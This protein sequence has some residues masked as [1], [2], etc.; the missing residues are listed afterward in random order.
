MV[1][2]IVFGVCIRALIFGNSHLVWGL[3]LLKGPKLKLL[4]TFLASQ[5]GDGS[6]DR[7]LSR[8]HDISLY[9]IPCPC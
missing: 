9:K 6:L 4:S 1:G 2:A 5:N 8:G 7:D 3:L